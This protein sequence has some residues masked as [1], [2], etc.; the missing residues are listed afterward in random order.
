[1]KTNQIR[2]EEIRVGPSGIVCA[3][4]RLHPR[5]IFNII[6]CYHGRAVTTRIDTTGGRRLGTH[7]IAC[8]ILDWIMYLIKA[9]V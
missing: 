2:G 6:K 4:L 1:M 7:F 5:T 3:W 8:Y 9:R